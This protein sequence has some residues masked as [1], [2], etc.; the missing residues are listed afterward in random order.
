MRRTR[1][2]QHRRALLAER[3]AGMRNAP[4]ATEAQLWQRLSG[5]RLGVGFR[6]QFVVGDFI[7]DFAAPSARLVVEVD[8]GYHA[9]P[10]FAARD[11]RRERALERAG[12][13][14]VRVSAELV[15]RDLEQAVALI[16]AALGE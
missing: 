12:W 2:T 15:Q 6:R 4:T 7:A 3:A 16:R 1:P 5:S 9:W 14:V 8:G 11:A 13:R 10:G